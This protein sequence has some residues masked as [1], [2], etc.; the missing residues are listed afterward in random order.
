MYLQGRRQLY[1]GA[2]VNYGAANPRRRK[3]HD[4]S[5]TEIATKSPLH[6]RKVCSIL[7][8]AT[9]LGGVLGHQIFGVKVVYSAQCC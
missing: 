4:T 8:N 5:I 9:L 2:G 7:E 6:T 1:F 3:A